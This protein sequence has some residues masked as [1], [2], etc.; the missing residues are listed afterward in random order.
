MSYTDIQQAAHN[1]ARLVSEG[2]A[3]VVKLEGGRNRAETVRFL[4]DQGIPVCAHLGLTPQSIHKFGGYHVQ[5]REESA[6]SQMIE[7]ASILQQAGAGLLVLECVPRD[8]AAEI[9]RILE[10]PTIGIGAGRHCDGE[11]LVL[12]DMLG[13]SHGKRPRFIKD[14]LTAVGGVDAAIRAFVSDVRSGAFPANEHSYE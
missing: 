3:E 11:V 8:L 7:D 2:F 1:A 6:A 4:V 9:T 14:Y 5:G 12:H 13:I 10:I